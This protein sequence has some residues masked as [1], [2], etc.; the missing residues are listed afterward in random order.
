MKSLTTGCDKL[1]SLLGGGIPVGVITL[2]YGEA[3]T[4]KTTLSL[5]VSIEASRRG[6]K[7]IYVD[8]DSSLTPTRLGWILKGLTREELEELGILFFKPL[9]FYEQRELIE[10]L[11]AYLRGDHRLIV[12]DSIT[13]LYRAALA[14]KGAFKLNRELGRQLAYLAELA[15]KKDLAILCTAQ[16][17]SKPMQGIIE[18]VARRVLTYW[19]K[20]ILRLRFPEDRKLRELKVEDFPEEKIKG[21]SI[22]LAFRSDGALCC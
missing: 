17:H 5:G 16:V 6:F 11:E 15:A 3:S 1:D 19:S 13:N 20:A 22:L 2:I 14:E 18:P 7:V 4:G 9:D 8:S 10:G 21:R 12:V